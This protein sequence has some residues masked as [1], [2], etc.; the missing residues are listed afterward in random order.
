MPKDKFLPYINIFCFFFTFINIIFYF[1]GY[2]YLGVNPHIDYYDALVIL[3][4]CFSAYTGPTIIQDLFFKYKQEYYW[5]FD[6]ST[7][8]IF[9]L[10]FISLCIFLNTNNYIIDISFLIVLGSLVLGYK[11]FKQSLKTP[12]VWTSMVLGSIIGLLMTAYLFSWGKWQSPF[13]TEQ[14]A[15]MHTDA[16][17]HPTIVH[18]FNTYKFSTTGL[19]SAIYLKYHWGTHLFFSGLS[20]LLHIHPVDTFS[21]LY[22]FYILPLS[23]KYIYIFSNRISSLFLFKEINPLLVISLFLIYYFNISLMHFLIWLSESV[24]FGIVITLMYLS[25][26]LRYSTLINSKFFL[27]FSFVICIVITTIKGPIGIILLG[28]LSWLMI[29]TYLFSKERRRWLF[30]LPLIIIGVYSFINMYLLQ[31]AHLGTSQNSIKN[32]FLKHS[33]SDICLNNM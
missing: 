19:N 15:L 1:V 6:S 30:V 17:F 14:F 20:N 24:L 8:D 13:L 31:D 21:L 4:F 10:I 12:L 11:F 3:S 28:V 25:I 16:L 32:F 27:L 26:L 9:F 29:R 33:F 7:I 5:F 2:D 22:P 18:L 23:L